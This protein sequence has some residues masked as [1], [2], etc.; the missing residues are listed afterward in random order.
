MSSF[1]M[2]YFGSQ[3][4]WESGLNLRANSVNMYLIIFEFVNVP[5]PFAVPIHSVVESASA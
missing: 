4:G 3:G 2:L 5:L 1:G